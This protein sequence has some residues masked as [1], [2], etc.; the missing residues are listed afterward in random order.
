MNAP[1]R[2]PWDL[3]DEIEKPVTSSTRKLADTLFVE[4]INGVHSYG[5]RLP[6]ERALTEEYG[7]SRNT[8]RQALSLME[9][10]GVIRRRVGSGSVVCY[11]TAGGAAAAKPA[12]AGEPAILDLGEI[13]EI[14][15][16][17]ELFVVRSI[18]EP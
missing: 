7:L 2:P 11:R 10:Y 15:K 14:T 16:P 17:L 6:A 12:P 18:V 5:T 4:I 3:D 9:H 1:E 13:G 8:I